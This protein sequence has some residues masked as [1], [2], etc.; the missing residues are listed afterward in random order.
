VFRVYLTPSGTKLAEFRRGLATHASISC[1]CL[2]PLA[3]WLA[4][5]SEKQTLHIFK[6]PPDQPPQKKE[7][8]ATWTE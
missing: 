1:M 6:M 5:S 3:S 2:S 4:V 8:T 7:E